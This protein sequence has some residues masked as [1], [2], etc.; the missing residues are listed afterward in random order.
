[1]RPRKFTKVDFSHTIAFRKEKELLSRNYE[2][3]KK[4]KDAI[5]AWE[6]GRMFGTLG[7]NPIEKRIPREVLGVN[8]APVKDIKLTVKKTKVSP[9][10]QNL[11]KNAM[12]PLMLIGSD[13]IKETLF[14]RETHQAIDWDNYGSRKKPEEVFESLKECYII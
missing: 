9:T 14:I 10:K 7:V 4:K 1:M 5:I 13:F 3:I 2:Q 11:V 12:M 6:V 8:F